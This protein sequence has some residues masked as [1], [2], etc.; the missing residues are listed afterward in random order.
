MNNTG[1]SI[2]TGVALTMAAG[3]A[4]ALAMNMGKNSSR[5]QKKK[6]K[7]GAA[8]MVRTVGQI[9]DDVAGSMR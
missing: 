5:A 7:R 9:V 1:K 3:T 6:L 2:A 8:R 4:A